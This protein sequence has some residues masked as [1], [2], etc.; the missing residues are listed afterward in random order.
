[1][2]LNNLKKNLKKKRKFKIKQYFNRF[3]ITKNNKIFGK[4]ITWF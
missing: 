3:Q 4:P 1:M 2:D